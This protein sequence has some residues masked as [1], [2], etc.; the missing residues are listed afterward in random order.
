M[1]PKRIAVVGGSTVY[2]QGDPRGGGFVARFRGWFEPL[3]PANRVFNL[4]VGGD[5]VADMLQRGASE[6]RARRPDQIILYPGLNDSRRLGSADADCTSIAEFHSTLTALIQELQ[7]IA[8]V[9]LMTSVPL[10]ESRTLPYRGSLYFRELDAGLLND[11]VRLVA[12]EIGVPCF[13]LFGRWTASLDWRA[14]LCDGIHCS[15]EGH[16]ILADDLQRYLTSLD[17]EGT[18]LTA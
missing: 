8:P 13:D 5:T 15:P 9:V 3:D 7:A 16:A 17:S 12:E 10:D 4:G 6:C 2:G 1:K 14:L 11:T 18:V